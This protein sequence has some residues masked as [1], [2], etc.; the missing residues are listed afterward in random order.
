M[1]RA[2]LKIF[3]VDSCVKVYEQELL[4]LLTDIHLLQKEYTIDMFAF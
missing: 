2:V 1:E 3:V 4:S